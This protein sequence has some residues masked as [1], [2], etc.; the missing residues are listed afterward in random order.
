MREHKQL[1]CINCPLG[2]QLDVVIEDGKIVSIENY[3]CQ[4]GIEYAQKEITSPKRTITS[5]IPV[6]GGDVPMV[7]VKTQS[8]IPKDKIKDC[9]LLL[10]DL[11]LNAPVAIGDVI[12]ENICD[13]GVD[14]IATKSVRKV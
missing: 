2:C 11:K 4:R 13:T 3:S 5:I 10:K 8:D 9:M 7:S 14:L 1:T 6:V 12:I